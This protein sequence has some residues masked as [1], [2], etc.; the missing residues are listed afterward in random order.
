MTHI[1]CSYLSILRLHV[2]STCD[3][4]QSIEK[5]VERG[6]LAASHVDDLADAFRRLGGEHVGGDNVRD[7]GE[8]ARL[9][10][11]AVDDG[12]LIAQERARETRDD[13]GIFR[14]W[15]L[16]WTEDIE[17]A[18]R[19]CLKIVRAREDLT[20][21]FTDELCHGIRRERIGPH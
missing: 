7:V 3:L 20:I 17:V 2:R 14:A 15:V 5:L 9:L 10:A 16:T 6:S 19:D 4:L 12:A 11:V 18:Q 8:I 1:A 21:V 13:A